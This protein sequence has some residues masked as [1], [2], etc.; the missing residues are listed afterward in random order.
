MQRAFRRLRLAIC[1]SLVGY[2]LGATPTITGFTPT[3]GVPGSI[4]ILIG[5]NFTGAT[6]VKFNGTVASRFIV[7]SA[8]FILAI[9]PSGVTT[10]KLSVTT[11]GGTAT[12]SGSFT[13]SNIPA[14][15]SFTPTSGTAGAIVSLA[16]ADFT[17]ATSVKFNGTE[18]SGFSVVSPTSITAV[19]PPGATTGTLSVTTANGTAYSVSN[20]IVG[21]PPSITMEPSNQTT[22]LGSPATFSVMAS[23]TAPLSYQWSKNGTIIPGATSTSY[24]TPTTVTGDTGAT[25]TV[26]VSNAYGN[27]TSSAASLTLNLPPIITTQPG[28]RT[29][30]LG[31]TATFNVVAS[32]SGTLSCLWSKNGTVIPGATSAS[33]T[34]PATVAGDAG[35]AFTVVVGNAYGN[36]TSTAATLTLNLPPAITTQPVDQTVTLGSTATF[37]VV[38]SGSGTLSYQWSKNGTIILGATSTSYTTPTAVAGDTNATF[39]VVVTNAYGNVTSSAA[40]LTLNLPPAITTQPVDQTVTLGSTATFN[41]VASGSGTLSY[42][43]SKNGTA[44]PGATSASYTTPTAVAGDTNATFTVI[45]TNAYGN[46]T[47]SAATLTLNQPPSITTQPVDQTVTL[48]S[49]ATF[50]VMASGTG[51]LSYQWSKNGTAIPG[52]TS[53]SYTSPAVVN[54]DNG[55][56]FAV[57]VTNAFG[58]IS[59]SAI[60]LIVLGG[61]SAPSAPII[62]FPPAVL[63]KQGGYVASVPAQ[64]GLSYSWG[65]HGGTIN[66]TSNT[67]QI[68]FTTG[69]VLVSRTNHSAT[70]LLDGRILFAGGHSDSWGVLN[71][72]ELYNPV[73]GSSQVLS[74]VSARAHHSATLLPSGRV[75]LVGGYGTTGTE[76][77]SAEVFDPATGTFASVGNATAFPRVGHTAVVLPDGRVFILGSFNSGEPGSSN[78]EIFDPT[79]NQF[80]VVN[81]TLTSPRISSAMSLLA[82]GRVLIAGGLDSA[83]NPIST[84]EV[85]DPATGLFTPT[86]SLMNVARV[87]HSATRLLDGRVLL[88]GG[89]GPGGSVLS[90]AEI[91]DPA[92]GSFTRLSGHMTVARMNATANLLPSGQVFIAGGWDLDFNQ[93]AVAECFDPS[94][95]LFTPTASLMDESRVRHTST[96]LADGR[97]LL[98]GG[99]GGSAAD[100]HV[101]KYFRPD[102]RTFASILSLSCIATNVSGAASPAAE[103]NIQ[104]LSGTS[105]PDIE[106]PVIVKAGQAGNLAQVLVPDSAG[107]T[108]AWTLENGIITS[109]STAAQ[110]TFTAGSAD[111]MVLTCMVTKPNGAVT[112]GA[113]Y[114]WIAKTATQPVI[115]APTS[116]TAGQSGCSALING[117]S[118]Y[119]YRWTITGGS[120]TE[121]QG[122]PRIQFTA[123]PIGTLHLG[124]VLVNA[125]GMASDPGSAD[126]PVLL[127]GQ[128]VIAAPGTVV[129]DTSNSANLVNP[130]PGFKAMWSILGGTITSDPTLNGVALTAPFPGIS[131][132]GD[133]ATLLPGGQVLFVGGDVGSRSADI[134]TASTSLSTMVAS[135][136]FAPKSGHTATLLNNGKVLLAGGHIGG[137][138]YDET[139]F[140]AELFDPATQSFTPIP[141]PIGSQDERRIAIA[142]KDGTVLLTGG[143][144]NVEG[145]IASTRAQIYDPLTNLFTT[146]DS[147]MTTGRVGCTATLLSDGRVLL[148]GGF[149]SWRTD[150]QNTAECFDPSTASFTPLAGTMSALRT[151]HTAT[152]LMDGRIL[153][154]GGCSNSVINPIRAELFD[155]ASGTFQPLS[156]PMISNRMAHTATLLPNGTVLLAGGN[157]YGQVS[158]E[159][160]DPSSLSFQP[161]RGPMLQGRSQHTATRLPNGSVLIAGGVTEDG[162]PG[163]K[164]IFD[165]AT[166]TFGGT[167]SLSCTATDPGGS[168]SG[169][170]TVQISVQ[171][172]VT[173]ILDPT[174]ALVLAG[175]GLP[176]TAQVVGATDVGLTWE[177]VSGEGT[178]SDGFFAAPYTPGTS[179]IK[180]TSMEDPTK[181]ATATITV[182]P[183]TTPVIRSLTIT[184]TLVPNGGTATIQADFGNGVGLIQPGGLPISSGSP[185]SVAPLKTT[186]YQLVVT[187]PDSGLQASQSQLV[188]VMAPATAGMTKEWEGPAFPFES[189]Q[190]AN[191]VKALRLKDGRILYACAGWLKFLDQ[192][193]LTFQDAL[194]RT[195]SGN[196]FGY[197]MHQLPNGKVV[198]LGG[199]GQSGSSVWTEGSYLFDPSTQTVQAIPL[200]LGNVLRYG[201]QSLMTSAGS[202][203][204]G[205]GQEK[206]ITCPWV[207]PAESELNLSFDLSTVTPFTYGQSTPLGEKDG[208]VLTSF[209]GLVNWRTGQKVAEPGNFWVR[210]VEMMDGRF[211]FG[212]SP[213]TSDGSIYNIDARTLDPLSNTLPGAPLVTLNDGRILVGQDLPTGY[214]DPGKDAWYVLPAPT[215]AGTRMPDATILL[216][217]G[218]ALFTLSVQNPDNTT[219]IKMVVFDPQ[220]PVQIHPTR[221]TVAM[222]C[223]QTFTI[224]GPEA[225]GGV[226]WSAAGGVIDNAG[227]WLAPQRPGRYRVTATS[228]QDPT[229]TSTAIVEVPVPPVYP[230]YPTLLTI[231]AGKSFQFEGPV[232]G[233][234]WGVKEVGGGTITQ[235]GLYTA[236]GA[237]GTYTIIMQRDPL[238]GGGPLADVSTVTV[239]APLPT[240]LTV[241]P[242]TARLGIGDSLTFSCASGGRPIQWGVT[243]GTMDASGTFTA[244]QQ[245]G[246]YQIL[247]VSTDGSELQALASV[248]VAPFGVTPVSTQ[249]P[250]G[251]VF[252][253]HTIGRPATL[254]WTASGGAIT[255]DGLYTAPTGPGTYIVTADAGDVGIATAT[256]TVRAG[257]PTVVFQ[258]ST[259]ATVQSGTAVQLSWQVTNAV[260]VTLVGMGDQPNSGTLP[261]TPTETTTYTLTATNEVG[262]T[263]VSLTVKV[264]RRMVWQNDKIYGFGHLISEDTKGSTGIDTTYVQ[265]DQVGSPDWVTDTKGT[266]VGRTK[267]LPFGERF[268]W[269]GTQ[270]SFRYAG[271]EDQPGSPV[272]MQARMYLP[273]YGKFGSPDPAY[274]QNSDDLQSM[275]LCGYVHNNP[276]TLIDPTGMAIPWYLGGN[277]PR[278]DKFLNFAHTV[279]VT[280]NPGYQMVAQPADL[281]AA[282]VNSVAN[283]NIPMSSN[284][285]KAAESG[286]STTSLLANHALEVPMTIIEGE[287]G[288]KLLGRFAGRVEEALARR[289][290]SNSVWPPNDGFLG[291]PTPRV[292]EPGTTVDRFGGA[293]GRFVAPEGTPV[294]ER[295]LRPGSDLT[296][297]DVFQVRQPIQ[298]QAGSAMPWF[299]QPGLGIQYKLPATTTS[300]VEQGYLLKIP[301]KVQP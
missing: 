179:V 277:S 45:V 301:P 134:Y 212:G 31:S 154:A 279:L 230:V 259:Q 215:I 266:Q 291:T 19:V 205:G 174:N 246:V 15:T 218:R 242:T 26:A 43:W 270:S 63:A 91:F 3:S 139:E 52:A 38:A 178:L 300:L 299:G 116:L 4:V 87:Q 295:S 143:G 248:E 2:L 23:G 233:F 274:D 227:K 88:A 44:I 8:R 223:T 251:Q 117:S 293:T 240:T 276:I 42:Q 252:Q 123:G 125:M 68:S 232:E 294:A 115:L 155:P 281:L 213:Y 94:T 224:T 185:I 261:V 18:A 48:G 263:T 171:P 50:S 198:F 197:T 202:I 49:S 148:A 39:T 98:A 99:L 86:Q 114:I 72:A 222:G 204:L 219:S 53:A 297:Y 172:A 275:N 181:F 36:V 51:T 106:A 24:T 27:V 83:S 199:A 243:G 290:T 254:Q 142:L 158:A 1:L 283:K 16:G 211:F 137:P 203:L 118:S 183:N 265:A 151:G 144:I 296:Q 206:S 146:L 268:L 109:D 255:A 238:L 167:L 62:T 250:P 284:L 138:Y 100:S 145:F 168:Q 280:A 14:I 231:E 292:L 163:L 122:T 153:L 102:T 285:G 7:V 288:G 190:V 157:G 111:Q 214:Y 175:T 135:P 166:G 81:A 73:D 278:V 74:M 220:S 71:T 30:T 40:T 75:L 133:T 256:V 201:H 46:V 170:A 262:T 210:P 32:G 221:A 140:P 131:R 124:C 247:V 34:S 237:P 130:Q 152:V 84:A 188:Q 196:Y 41:V 258:A 128:P 59:S 103:A 217:D 182:A 25:F 194:T 120:I 126:I 264:A 9:V 239:V 287:V 271:H 149:D 189:F 298:V 90:D 225:A 289:A 228:V 216:D 159:I 5:T 272:Y 209:G 173:V 80:S 20:F 192:S 33:Y 108:Y 187:N 177:L 70:L 241:S 161:T 169:A 110:V 244:P 35:A 29:V 82:D 260:T 208:L 85:F 65:I 235:D 193:T 101:A 127:V 22:T 12:S 76:P 136:L 200:V 273:A 58:S 162:R 195:M 184:P 105:S 47:S 112:S 269:A 66:G 245:P 96:L 6:S 56:R 55:A 77:S 121:G 95:G 67:N 229:H 160:F 28:D 282:T 226:T 286:A 165:P 97:V 147:T 54:A 249:V 267:N 60:Q 107:C 186:L 79:T 11:S 78:A 13:V 141:N 253:F 236:S 234:Y 129:S 132:T 119:D 17:G 37:N 21:L 113:A 104:V 64:D 69:N 164:E 257:L 191:G 92:V 57:L 180:V 93:S 10:G 156:A 207:V 61:S 150:G 89:S 176:I